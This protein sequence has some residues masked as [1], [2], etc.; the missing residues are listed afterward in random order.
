M[1]RQYVGGENGL[2]PG[3]A[4]GECFWCLDAFHFGFQFFPSY[5]GNDICKKQSCPWPC[6][7]PVTLRKP[8]APARERSK[9]CRRM[10][11]PAGHMRP[12]N[13]RGPLLRGSGESP[14]VCSGL[15]LRA[16]L[17][18]LVSPLEGVGGVC[19]ALRLP[20]AADTSPV[21]LTAPQCMRFL[22]L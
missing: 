19:V 2:S 18:A 10:S 17:L 12:H 4:A 20:K 13:F 22:S 14:A 15:S 8:S 21:S 6:R 11:R 9:I 7:T 5:Y 16:W 1:R 3:N